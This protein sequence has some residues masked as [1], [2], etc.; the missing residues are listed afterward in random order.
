MHSRQE[1]IRIS[2]GALICLLFLLAINCVSARIKESPAGGGWLELDD[3][4]D[5]VST[6]KKWFSEE[7]FGELTAEAWVYIEEF[8]DP[9]SYWSI[10]GQEG[11]FNMGISGA[12]GYLGVVVHG[13]NIACTAISAASG[14]L[15]DRWIHFVALCNAGAGFGQDGSGFGP[16][17]P[18]GHL[19]KTDKPLRIG[20]IIPKNLAGASFA[21]ENV[22]FRGY[23]DEVRISSTLRYFPGGVNFDYQ[24]PEDRFE[25]DE[26][27]LC[28]WHFDEGIES[29][30]YEDS[31]GNGY[32]LWRSEVYAVQALGKLSTAWGKI[33]K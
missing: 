29:D 28:L 3:E 9:E 14:I 5:F 27:T 16:G 2:F 17:A 11:R 25:V 26:D 10:I 6:A 32:H 31:S 24:V 13:D 30:R 21:G 8:P 19:W 23:I 15:S 22:K 18:G 1:F 7:Q 33:K 12:V 4:H 20:G